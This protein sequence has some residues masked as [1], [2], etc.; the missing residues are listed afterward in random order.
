V[1]RIEVERRAQKTLSRLPRQDQVRI[2]AAIDALADRLVF[3][4]VRAPKK[5]PASSSQ[6]QPLVATLDGQS[7]QARQLSMFG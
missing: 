1:Y 6:Q 7:V 2:E 5:K 4:Q 3:G